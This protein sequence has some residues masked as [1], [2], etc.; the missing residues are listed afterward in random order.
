MR[1]TIDYN[2]T[3]NNFS[4]LVDRVMLSA[5]GPPWPPPPPTNEQ[6]AEMTSWLNDVYTKICM[7]KF[8]NQNV[9]GIEFKYEPKEGKSYGC[10]YIEQTDTPPEP[11]PFIR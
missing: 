7:E 4:V 5:D 6:F 1:I 10:L 11:P 8:K 3:N 9:S 2:P